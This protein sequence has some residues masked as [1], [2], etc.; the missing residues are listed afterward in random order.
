M[1]KAPCGALVRPAATP[2]AKQGR[3]APYRLS[4]PSPR[5]NRAHRGDHLDR[6]ADSLCGTT[7]PVTGHRP[8]PL[9]FCDQPSPHRDGATEHGRV[10]PPQLPHQP[11]HLAV[12]AIRG[13]AREGMTIMNTTQTGPHTGPHTGT[14]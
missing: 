7:T 8:G 11:R 9:R 6:G 12:C 2:S 13:D 3:H 10:A 14:T 4:R 1:A 5:V